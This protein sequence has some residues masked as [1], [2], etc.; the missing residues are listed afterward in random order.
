ME[1]KIETLARHQHRD[2]TST[3]AIRIALA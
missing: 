2:V 3:W 1:K